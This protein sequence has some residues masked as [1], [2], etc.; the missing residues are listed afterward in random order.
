[1]FPTN[2]SQLILKLIAYEQV[3]TSWYKPWIIRFWNDLLDSVCQLASAG[4]GKRMRTA[5]IARWIFFAI[6]ETMSLRFKVPHAV[7]GGRQFPIAI[8]VSHHERELNPWGPTR[9]W[10]R[11]DAVSARIT[12]ASLSGFGFAR[13]GP[14]R[15]SQNRWQIGR[16]VD[17]GRILVLPIHCLK[18]TSYQKFD[19]FSRSDLEYNPSHQLL[20][21]FAQENRPM[22]TQPNKPAHQLRPIY[23][24][25]PIKR[26]GKSIF[27]QKLFKSV[28][29]LQ[30]YCIAPFV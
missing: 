5:K 15:V 14:T 24:V 22:P 21:C 13:W 1:M 12:V 10:R 29:V 2:R 23:L 4:D 16:L 6:R 3:R 8:G 9:V 18:M 11:S 17:S 20:A 27:Q 25:P 28:M 26:K 19:I 30:E 7:L